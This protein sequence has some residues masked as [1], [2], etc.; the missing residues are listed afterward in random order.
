MKKYRLAIFLTISACYVISYFHRAA[1]AVVGPEL[2]RTLGFSPDQLG[3]IGSMY[4]WAY[5]LTALPSGM[6]SDTWGARKTI[7][8]F[9]L[10]AAVGSCIFGASS[11]LAFLSFGRFA[12]G[13]GVGVVYVA[14]MRIFSDW[15]RPDE[16]ATISGV[17]LAVGNVGALLSTTPLV[18]AMHALGW[19]T[20][21]IA[22]AVL[23]L[24]LSFLAY[25]IIRNRPSDLPF[26]A[27]ELAGTP[28]QAGPAA[29]FSQALRTVFRS[30]RLYMLGILLFSYYGTLMGFGS[31]W[32]GPYL[33][34]ALSFSERTAGNILM[35]FPIGMIIG[36]PLAGY[37]SDK[38]FQSRKRILF[39]GAL[40]HAGC[41]AVFL[42]AA[43][44]LGTAG[45]YMLFL[46]YGLTG[47][48]FVV[49][50]ACV[51]EIFPPS[52]AGTAV[53]AINM[54][55][56]FGGAFYQYLIGVIINWMMRDS[57]P[58]LDAYRGGL[59][60]SALGL[61]VGAAVFCFFRETAPDYSAA[62]PS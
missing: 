19:R 15:Y 3:L 61:V 12:I 56:F 45:L 53:G 38:I 51:K 1:P 58:L 54:F 42:L 18:F 7:A 30:K 23:T 46:L 20:T 34:N 31:L 24:A 2:V 8:V 5:A 52:F 6:L 33:Q 55:L 39:Y 47:S 25:R 43:A 60:I 22:I 26:P 49:C 17:L 4:F 9:I 27:E 59:F 16:L 21:F 32:A 36:C 48:C 41:Y 14:A 62:D 28:V 37:L 57:G 10:V 50:F 29:T 11:S 44:Q 35:M 40:L 13:I